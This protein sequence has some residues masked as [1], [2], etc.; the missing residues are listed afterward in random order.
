MNTKILSKGTLNMI[1][2]PSLW[3]RYV[4]TLYAYSQENS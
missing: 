2:E 4:I 1:K 3:L